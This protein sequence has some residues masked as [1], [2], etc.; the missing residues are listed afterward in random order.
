MDFQ[1]WT[2]E[3]S[4]DEASHLSLLDSRLRDLSSKKGL[5][6]IDTDAVN[7]RGLKSWERCI[8]F[9]IGG[10]FNALHFRAHFDAD[11]PD[12][13]CRYHVCGAGSY[14][15]SLFLNLKG[16]YGDNLDEA[17][18]SFETYLDCVNN[19]AV[20]VNLLRPQNVWE[21][22]HLGI[23][24]GFKNQAII[25]ASTDMKRLWRDFHMIEFRR[26]LW[27]NSSESTDSNESTDISY[28]G[29]ELNE[30]VSIS[31]GIITKVE[32][33]YS[34]RKMSNLRKEMGIVIPDPH[35]DMQ[36]FFDSFMGKDLPQPEGRTYHQI[37]T[38]EDKLRELPNLLQDDLK[39]VYEGNGVFEE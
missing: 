26:M 33:S 21:D 15:D 17:L 37:K 31:K 1:K 4:S 24:R 34:R 5:S 35:V 38:F 36:G 8:D 10:E 12:K 32:N 3:F 39:A 25:F 16:Y 11:Y 29:R 27:C 13:P 20:P 14:H 6:L 2:F 23:P 7:V 19:K 18:A 30:R 28:E 22:I 9:D